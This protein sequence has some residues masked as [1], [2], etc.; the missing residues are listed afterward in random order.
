M[1]LRETRWFK[2]SVVT[3]NGA[4]Y[5]SAGKLLMARSYIIVESMYCTLL[6]PQVGEHMK[7]EGIQETN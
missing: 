4:N 3:D 2:L 1:A 5:K 6:G 7:L